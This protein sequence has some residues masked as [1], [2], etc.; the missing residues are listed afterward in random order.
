MADCLS[1]SNPLPGP[2]IHLAGGLDG[3]GIYFYQNG[4]LIVVV[5]KAQEPVGAKAG[6]VWHLTG[7]EPIAAG[8]FRLRD[9]DAP[10]E[11]ALLLL[12][13]WKCRSGKLA[14]W[15]WT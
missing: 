4:G 12:C 3:G 6:L 11:M 8:H 7:G 13:E 1:G 15:V 2:P 10:M 9:G 5:D 14:C